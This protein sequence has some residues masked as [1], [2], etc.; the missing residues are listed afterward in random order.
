MTHDFSDKNRFYVSAI[1]I[2]TLAL[3]LPLFFTNYEGG[4]CPGG[5]RRPPQQPG[6]SPFQDSFLVFVFLPFT[7]LGKNGI[8]NVMFWTLLI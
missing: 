1:I 6:L 7:D 4:L 3:V 5:P 8:L 2:M